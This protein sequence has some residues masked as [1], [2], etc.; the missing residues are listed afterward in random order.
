[1]GRKFLSK[2][3]L[4][5]C[6][7][8]LAVLVYL[9]STTI[10]VA[11]HTQ[12]MTHL[13]K[14]LDYNSKLDEVVMKLHLGVIQD[15]DS[16]SALLFALKQYERV[17]QVGND[18]IVG[19]G[20]TEVDRV[21]QAYFEAMVDKEVLLERF[22]SL[23]ALSKNSY[24]YLPLSVDLLSSDARTPNSVREKAQTA[25]R[26][27]LLLPPSESRRHEREQA[28]DALQQLVEELSKH[29]AQVDALLKTV[30]KHAQNVIS[31]REELNHLIVSITE[32][33]IERFS[34]ELM[35]VY[36]RSF[37][38]DMGRAN[39]YRM[40]LLL[41]SASL[42]AYAIYIFFRLNNASLRLQHALSKSQQW[43]K[44]LKSSKLK[45]ESRV[46]ER[47]RELSNSEAQSRSIVNN[48]VDG[49]V[50]IDR[51]GTILSV[52]NA[53][54]QLFG[55]Q[56]ASLI[57]KNVK[58]LMPEP[59]YSEHD[60]YLQRYQQT[61]EKR[62]IGFRHELLARHKD[63][64]IFPIELG[65]SETGLDEGPSFT[66]IIS[67]IS[68]RKRAEKV[69]AV[70]KNLAETANEAKGDF[71]AN[72][73]HEIRTPM[74]AIIGLS[75]LCLKTGLQPKQR[76]YVTKVN[77]AAES[78]L[79]IINDILD[80][81][82]IEAGK[83]DLEAIEF[84]LEEVLSNLTIMI[85]GK[86]HDQ[87][88]DL[89]V[90]IKPE[91]PQYLVGDPLR[92]GQVLI[93]LANNAVKFTEEG[94]VSILVAP[95]ASAEEGPEEGTALRFTVRDT[96][97]GMDQ[98]QIKKLFESFSQADTSTTRV[99][100]GS[101]LGLAICKRLVD[102]MAGSITV[103]SEP[104]QGSS[105]HID[106]PFGIASA[107]RKQDLPTD[108]HGLRVLVVD[109]SKTW[110]EVLTAQLEAF[111]F[112]TEAV[113]NGEQ[114]LARIKSEPPFDLVL[115][116]WNMPGMNGVEATHRIHALCHP[117]PPPIIIMITAYSR[118]ELMEQAKNEKLGVKVFLDKPV[119]A[120]VLFDTLM[121]VFEKEAPAGR[122]PRSVDN[123][124]EETIAGLY[125]RRLLLV[126]D[127]KFNQQVAREVLE[128]S[129]LQVD[130][131][132]NGREAVERV[133]QQKYAAILMD[134][135]MPE[136]DGYEATRQIRQIPRHAELPIIA[137]TANVMAAAREHCF[138]AGMNDHIGKPI[139][140]TELF[141]TLARWILSEQTG[142]S[143]AAPERPLVKASAAS[144][145]QPKEWPKSD[146]AS[147]PPL[148][149]SVLTAMVGDDP[150][151]H[152]QLVTDFIADAEEIVQQIH[153][154]YG[155][156]DINEMGGLGHKLKSSAMIVG[157]HQLAEL[158]AKLETRGHSG[159]LDGIEGLLRELD[160]CMTAVKDY[161]RAT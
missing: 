56:G 159:E 44:E 123:T 111:H 66:G 151:F 92:L 6:F 43:S 51:R 148:D 14:L 143:G 130:I 96:G 3:F 78:L 98:S 8:T 36:S 12:I 53:I 75:A 47:T 2:L 26:V 134:V 16:L 57:G 10:D 48:M 149:L 103:E 79:G 142:F 109:D 117:D 13:G 95:L 55:Y 19:R 17:L 105:F 9:N 120:S 141:A 125:G 147:T 21:V 58:V 104:G 82:K 30:V 121:Q 140:P 144:I 40:L 126:E 91:T 22:K 72:M 146:L 107:Q 37:Y 45:L 114:A 62:V 67:D 77:S 133:G 64:T 124:S 46:S 122:L 73:S 34:Q 110:C 20:D 74:N 127:N 153:G 145:A 100:G 63:G 76:D 68:E 86:T 94:E 70:A 158:C 85:E 87:G 5:A 150:V 24:T 88:L 11:R 90:G 113:F 156:G 157:A 139:N 54:E 155:K 25:L 41:M 99:Y 60:G 59:Y 129:G 39:I 15:Y 97:I 115:M 42:F 80:F 35:E 119:S 7:A 101:G 106:I 84:D 18:A 137:M 160:A 71:L 50:C 152:Q 135:Q 29:P 61:G 4:W 52:N 128:Q 69:L 161:H 93:N 136:M 118:E 32:A 108:L 23:N 31:S 28:V 81:S 33:D 102:M 116:D 154:A 112:E 132:E 49:L 83:L 65:V 138:E 131:A 38:R 1:M 89:V 27:I